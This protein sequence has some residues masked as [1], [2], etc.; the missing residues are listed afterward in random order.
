MVL[1]QVQACRCASLHMQAGLMHLD[2]VGCQFDVGL[3]RSGPI[4]HLQELQRV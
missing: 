3:S 1:T 4:T 2:V